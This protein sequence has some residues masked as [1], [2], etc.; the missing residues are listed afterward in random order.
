MDR[1]LPFGLIIAGTLVGIVA[2][3]LFARSMTG[4][5][6]SVAILARALASQ[7]S[8]SVSV[9]PLAVATSFLLAVVGLPITV[10][11]VLHRLERKGE[12]ERYQI[13]GEGRSRRRFKTSHGDRYIRHARRA[14]SLDDVD[15]DPARVSGRRI[16][17]LASRG[18][19]RED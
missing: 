8:G 5:G 16:H 7:Y 19:D 11:V 18:E 9:W 12:H 17:L 10:L 2:G 4:S 6:D 14:H 1:K 3:F 13:S 15:T